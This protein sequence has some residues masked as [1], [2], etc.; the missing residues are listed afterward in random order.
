MGVTTTTVT[1]ARTDARPKAQP[2]VT[3]GGQGRPPSVRALAT[4]GF[5]LLE[6]LVAFVI[7]ALALGVLFH[8]GLGGLRSAQAAS[9][10]EQAIARARSHLA[11]AV[12][13][14]PLAAGDWRGD[15]G[16]G[17]TWH[18]RVAP[19]AS[20]AAQPVYAL[21]PLRAASIPVTL[22]AVTVWI[23]WHDSS[24]RE[25]RLETEQIGQGTR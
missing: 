15:D 18:L 19:I 16:G 9:H 4:R 3:E 7:A 23:A 11:L 8:A 24:I 17:F 21:T 22:Y 12:H 2:R 1:T 14:N 20:T 10:Y 25:V 13:A 6:V 5:T